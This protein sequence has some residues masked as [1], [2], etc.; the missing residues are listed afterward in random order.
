MTLPV[1]V[2]L[3]PSAFWLT[4]R[5]DAIKSVCDKG[6]VRSVLF[7]PSVPNCQF[8]SDSRTVA[9]MSFMILLVVT[10]AASISR[11]RGVFFAKGDTGTV[12]KDHTDEAHMIG[13]FTK[14]QQSGHDDPVSSRQLR[15]GGK[16]F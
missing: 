15:T 6:T 11:E 7:G 1:S 4:G 3:R 14:I 2:M 12:R 5:D 13:N 8:V 16:F 9:V 10:L